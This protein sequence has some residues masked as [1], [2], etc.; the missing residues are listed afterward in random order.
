MLDIKHFLGGHDEEHLVPNLAGL[1]MGN[2][3]SPCRSRPGRMAGRFASA[4]LILYGTSR[5]GRSAVRRIES[6]PH[7]CPQLSLGH[8][9][10]R[11]PAR[12]DPRGEVRFHMRPAF[13]DRSV[14]RLHPHRRAGAFLRD[15]DAGAGL[16]SHCDPA[17]RRSDP[18]LPRHAARSASL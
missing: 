2:I 16:H 13:T 5:R 4:L 3:R 1:D 10:A 6:Q 12:H 11:G 15:L 9:A 18:Q 17:G 8:A 7:R 14:S